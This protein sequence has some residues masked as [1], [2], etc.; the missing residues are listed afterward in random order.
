MQELLLTFI[1][2]CSDELFQSHHDQSQ[3][4]VKC[5]L[6]TQLELAGRAGLG[7]KNNC[8][9]KLHFGPDRPTTS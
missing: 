3:N 8:I 4:L 1:S 6:Q 2:S 9:A 7:Q 5:G